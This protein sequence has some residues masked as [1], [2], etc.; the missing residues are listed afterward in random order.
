MHDDWKHF[1]HWFWH[2]WHVSSF[3]WPI[4]LVALVAIPLLL[5]LYVVKERRGGGRTARFANPALMPNLVAKRPRWR[6]HADLPERRQGLPAR[7]L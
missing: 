3:R 2:N 5:L 4:V 1:H 7:P 6:R